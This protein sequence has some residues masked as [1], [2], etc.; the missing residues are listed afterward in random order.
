M[1]PRELAA[2][3]RF[4]RGGAADAGGASRPALAR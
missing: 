3:M 2:A 4:A 1:T